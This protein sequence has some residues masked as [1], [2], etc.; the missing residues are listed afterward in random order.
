MKN[1]HEDKKCRFSDCRKKAT[2]VAIWFQPEGGRNVE[3]WSYSCDDC[4]ESLKGDLIKYQRRG[5]KPR[6]FKIKE[7]FIFR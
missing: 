6:L 3:V 2:Y 5:W 1:P 7:V 4:L